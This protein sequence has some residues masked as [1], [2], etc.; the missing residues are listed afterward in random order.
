MNNEDKALIKAK[1]IQCIIGIIFLIPP[2]LCVLGFI[3]IVVTNN[4]P[5]LD[6]IACMAY[7]WIFGYDYNL[8]FGI[9]KISIAPIYIGMMAFI[10]AYLIKDSLI[11]FFIK[12]EK[13]KE[14]SKTEE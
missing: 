11:Y 13:P 1:R 14:K 2:I 5:G 10:G 7:K 8:D 4:D 6:D 9:D 3:Y 12:D